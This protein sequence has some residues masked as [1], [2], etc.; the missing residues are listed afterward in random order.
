MALEPEEVVDVSEDLLQNSSDTPSSPF[1]LDPTTVNL[2]FGWGVHKFEE[3]HY[4]IKVVPPLCKT[5]HVIQ[6]TPENK[7][8]T[9]IQGRTVTLE[10]PVAIKNNID[11]ETVVKIMDQSKA[12]EGA[13]LESYSKDCKGGIKK[14]LM[15]A[16]C[17]GKKKS[18]RRK[19][20]RHI[21]KRAELKKQAIDRSKRFYRFKKNKQKECVVR[22]E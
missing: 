1:I 4:Y 12:C 2:P 17:R 10:A 3:A 16:Q 5:S 13:G 9:S 20:K 14:G 7:I 6:L 21:R 19:Q 8:K 11:M 18:D 22:Y 15:W